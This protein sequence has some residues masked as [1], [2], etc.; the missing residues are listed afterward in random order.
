MENPT[1]KKVTHATRPAPYPIRTA[2][3]TPLEAATAATCVAASVVAST[4]SETSLGISGTSSSA[5]EASGAMAVA[6]AARAAALLFSC[7]TSSIDLLIA[8][9]VKD[10]RDATCWGA[11][12]EAHAAKTTRTREIAWTVFMVIVGDRCQGAEDQDKNG[13]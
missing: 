1:A 13:T 2:S 9:A 10:G 11:K 12:A 8:L 6:K 7:G 3:S 5:K 4:T